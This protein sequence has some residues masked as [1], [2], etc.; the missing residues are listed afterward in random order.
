M[1]AKPA[2]STRSDNRLPAVLDAAAHLFAEKGYAATS[3]REIALACDML[4]G[5]LYYHFAAKEDLL[6][7]VY[8]AGVHQLIEAGRLTIAGEREPWARLEAGCAA[9]LETLLQRSD[10]AQVLVRVL[11]SDVPGAAARLKALRAEYERQFRELVGELPL[12]PATDRGLLRLMLLGALNWSRFWFAAGGRETPRSL[13]R[14][15]VQLLQETH[16]V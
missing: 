4:P 7:A 3:M 14:K 10:F 6:V 9:H 8:E 5:S 15:F 16:H 12:P 2:K 11:P 1:I 13:A